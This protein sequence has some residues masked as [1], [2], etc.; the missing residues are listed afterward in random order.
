MTP[1]A[2]KHSYAGDYSQHINS[3]RELLSEISTSAPDPVNTGQQ[4]I[5]ASTAPPHI[6]NVVS[7]NRTNSSPATGL[8]V[9]T[10]RFVAAPAR[11]PTTL[12]QNV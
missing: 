6:H 8:I 1:G 10:K 11:K 12:I 5:S 3:L 7:R 4:P 9:L 2:T